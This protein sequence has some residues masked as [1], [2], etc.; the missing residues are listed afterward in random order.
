MAPPN[1]APKL[2]EPPHQTVNCHTPATPPQPNPDPTLTPSTPPQLNR[3][4]K[5]GQIGAAIRAKSARITVPP[6]WSHPPAIKPQ[7]LDLGPWTLDLG[8]DPDNPQPR[9]HSPDRTRPHHSAKPGRRLI[10]PRQVG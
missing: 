1:L 3:R 5:N 4:L 7:T 9:R 6:C 8:L 10:T 2:Y